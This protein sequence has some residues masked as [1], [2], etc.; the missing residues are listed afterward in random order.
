MAAP[1]VVPF[2][3]NPS[4]ISQKTTSYTIPAGKY[5]YVIPSDIRATVNGVE[6]F[7]GS[8]LKSVTANTGGYYYLEEGNC[9]ITIPS[10]TAS[11]TITKHYLGFS[12]VTIAVLVTVSAGTP[13]VGYFQDGKW[14]SLTGYTIFTSATAPTHGNDYLQ[15]FTLGGSGTH[16][17]SLFHGQTYP[18]WV[19]SGTVL[20]GSSWI[21]QEYN[22]IS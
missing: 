10:T 12:A 4:S 13:L 21:V 9:K 18:L 5:A 1:I 22:N 14:L 2:N 15:S 3:N 8:S 20:A 7:I 16:T 19:P 11:K 6:I 17:V